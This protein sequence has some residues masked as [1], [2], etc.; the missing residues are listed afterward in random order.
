MVNALK[1]KL[2]ISQAGYNTMVDVLSAGCRA[3]VVPFAE[4]GETE[5][6]RRAELLE[7]RERVAVVTEADLTGER[8]SEAIETALSQEPDD[9][10]LDLSGA[11]NSA[12]ILGQLL[13]TQRR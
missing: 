10:D 7:Q 13:D 11:A 3:V 12:R 9:L 2:S 1:G 4:G 5:Q 6:S 8:L